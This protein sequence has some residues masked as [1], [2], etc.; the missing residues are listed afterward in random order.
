[1]VWRKSASTATSGNS[2]SKVTNSNTQKSLPLAISPASVQGQ[3]S[4]EPFVTS[5]PTSFASAEM[6]N[7]MHGSTQPTPVQTT[8]P[9]REVNVAQI[10]EQVSRILQRQLTVERERRGM[11]LWY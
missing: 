4:R 2:L 6:G 8:T 7:G 1:M 3:L 10:A 11:N 5:N 9:V